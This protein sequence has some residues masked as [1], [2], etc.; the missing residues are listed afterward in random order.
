VYTPQLQVIGDIANAIWQLK[1]AITPPAHWDW[2]RVLR[3][4]APMLATIAP[5]TTD[6]RFGGKDVL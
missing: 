4:R 5:A 1:E 6:E 2:S 3:F